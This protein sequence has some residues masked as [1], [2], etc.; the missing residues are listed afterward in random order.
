VVRASAAAAPLIATLMTRPFVALS[1]VTRPLTSTP[2]VAW[3]NNEPTDNDARATIHTISFFMGDLRASQWEILAHFTP[4][5]AAPTLLT[6][7]FVDKPFYA[8]HENNK[9][10]EPCPQ[11]KISLISERRSKK[12]S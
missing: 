2:V 10:E 4:F 3:A 12:R 6:A 11:P 7:V 5:Q 8:T 1:A 9:Q